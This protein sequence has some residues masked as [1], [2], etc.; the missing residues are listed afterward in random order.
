MGETSDEQLHLYFIIVH[1]RRQQHEM[2][3]PG[4]GIFHIDMIENDFRGRRVSDCLA[5]LAMVCL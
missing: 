1:E 4:V 2:T 3:P 5:T